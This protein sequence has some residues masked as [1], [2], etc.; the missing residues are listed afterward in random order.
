MDTLNG[1]I[2]RLN[3][4]ESNPSFFINKQDVSPKKKTLQ[5]IQ[6]CYSLLTSRKYG[7]DPDN[8][9]ISLDKLFI[10][11]FDDE[12]IWQ[13]LELRINSFSSSI[14]HIAKLHLATKELT[15]PFLENKT[16][17]SENEVNKSSDSM[18]ISEEPSLEEEEFSLRY[19]PDDSE[20]GDNSEDD[21]SDKDL[22]SSISPGKKEKKLHK[23]KDKSVAKSV[24]DDDFFKLSEM[25]EF[26]DKMEQENLPDDDIDYFE[27]TPSDA[28]SQTKEAKYDDFFGTP[29][30]ELDDDNEGE[31]E[32]RMDDESDASEDSTKQ[33]KKVRFSLNNDDDYGDSEAEG[34]ANHEKTSFEIRDSKL[35]QKITKLEESNLGEKPW[36]YKGEVD[37]TN[38]PVNSLL[39]EVLDVDLTVRPPPVITEKVTNTL[40]QI[41]VNRIKDSAY[42]DVERKIKPVHVPHELKKELV[43]N[44]EKSKYSLAE[45]YEQEFLKRQPT[46]EPTEDNNK[47]TP[48]KENILKM[49]KSVFHKLD[50][51]SNF[52]YTP[53]PVSADLEIVSNMPAI[54]I[55]EVT[56]VAMSDANLLAPQEVGD[57]AKKKLL[58][59]DER[60]K[61]DKR[62]ERR[63]KKQ[64]LSHKFKKSNKTNQLKSTLKSRNVS[65]A[66]PTVESTIKSSSSFFK[67]LQEDTESGV[68]IKKK[69]KKQK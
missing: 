56:P 26:L 39:E 40:E 4:L 38:R 68:K 55:E 61:T 14:P 54:T 45:I 42:D 29:G 36:V 31:I 34:K 17:P 59:K 52:H 62:R 3:K 24:V 10:E 20:L 23:K 64:F 15:F 16:S 19:E 11:G 50:T 30:S 8:N 25:E 60:T 37:A 57:K 32:E 46:A 49:M 12:Q 7:K 13:Q 6:Q 58:G 65:L 66:Q 63:K 9:D 44:Q 43:L 51:L 35:K 2:N 27:D 47:L 69:T 18:V 41:I 21:M 53:K 67:K 28:E 48:E 5:I 33:H 1:V 22:P